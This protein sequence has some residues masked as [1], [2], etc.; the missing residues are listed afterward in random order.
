MRFLLLTPNKY[1]Y[2]CESEIPRER[3]RGVCCVREGRG[4]IIVVFVAVFVGFRPHAV[5]TMYYGR[6]T[7]DAV[8]LYS[9]A[10]MSL[11]VCM[12]ISQLFGQEPLQCCALFLLQAPD[13]EREQ[14]FGRAVS[15]PALRLRRLIS[16]LCPRSSVLRRGVRRYVHTY[17]H[18]YIYIH[19]HTPVFAAHVCTVRR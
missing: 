14:M 10:R 8:R 16:W 17:I 1:G 5:H 11:C 7:G 13:I 12:Y 6:H 18:T 19:S 3:K 15:R 2:W 9:S 4:A